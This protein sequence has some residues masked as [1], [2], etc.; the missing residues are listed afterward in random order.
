MIDQQES[1]RDGNSS[2]KASKDKEGWERM[3]R[4]GEQHTTYHAVSL[5][6]AIIASCARSDAMDYW[7]IGLLDY[8]ES[9]RA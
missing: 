6:G 8:C 5:R 2:R 1:Q 3:G 4:D 7:I 9:A